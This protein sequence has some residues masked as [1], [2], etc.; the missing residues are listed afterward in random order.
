LLDNDDGRKVG[1]VDDDL[2]GTL[3]GEAEGS[4]EPDTVGLAL[5]ISDGAADGIADE[6][7]IGGEVGFTDSTSTGN[8]VGIEEGVA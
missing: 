7:R 6:A 4:D 2:V 5:G 3:V 8:F 1:A